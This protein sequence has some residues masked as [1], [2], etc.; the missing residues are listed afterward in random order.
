MTEET[1]RY[2]VIVELSDT[3]IERLQILVPR[4]QNILARLSTEPPQQA[5][6]SVSADMF[7]Y[8]IRSTLVAGQISARIESPGKQGPRHGPPI[9]QPVLLGKDSLFI[10]EIGEDFSAG[11][12]FTRAGAWLQHH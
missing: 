4:L 6:R 7:G 12:G 2:L 5:F 8:F 9:E 3:A 1:R 10:I 11:R